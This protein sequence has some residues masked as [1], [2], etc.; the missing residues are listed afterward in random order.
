M[1]IQMRRGSYKD[2]DPTKLLPGEMAVVLD[3]D[4]LDE[5]GVYVNFSS[6]NTQ[7]LATTDSIKAS[8]LAEND[9][10]VND[11]IE[12]NEKEIKDIQSDAQLAM[13]SANEAYDSA[14]R[15]A[16]EAEQAKLAANTATTTANEAKTIATEAKASAEQAVTTA[17]NA[18]NTASQTWD[19]LAEM[20][21]AGQIAG[22]NL[23]RNSLVNGG[24]VSYNSSQGTYVENKFN[25]RP[26]YK[27]TAS[28]QGIVFSNSDFYSRNGISVGNAVT[29][30][31]YV[32]SEV[33][34]EACT[35]Y[36]YRVTSTSATS[37]IQTNA[38]LTSRTDTSVKV[39]MSAGV[40]Y[41]LWCTF[42]TT[43]YTLSATSTRFEC[44]LDKELWWSSPKAEKG[45]QVTDWTPA[46]EDYLT[47]VDEK[48]EKAQAT[49][50]QLFSRGE[51]LVVNG[52]AILKDNTNFSS[53]TFDGE[54]ANNSC[55]AFTTTETS[56]QVISSDYSFPVNPSL[57]YSFEMDAKSKNNKAQMY[58]FLSLFDIDNKEI[59]S[60]HCLYVTGTLTSLTQ[61]LK[62]GDTVVYLDDLSGWQTSGSADTQS[63]I[64]WN[65]KNSFGYEYPAETYSR[66]TTS[67]GLFEFSS[68][69][70]TN[71]TITLKKPWSG[72]SYSAGTQL[73]QGN[74]GSSFLYQGMTGATPSTTWTH[75]AGHY[76]GVN[77]TGQLDKGKFLPG[78]AYAKVGFLWDYNNADDQVWVTNISVKTD[79]QTGINE[80]KEVASN[81]AK[82]ATNYLSTNETGDVCLGNLTNT[83][84]KGNV[85]LKTNGVS[86][87]ND[88]RVLVDVTDAK[89]TLGDE[90]QCCVQVEDDQLYIVGANT[91]SINDNSFN[92]FIVAQGNSG[93]WYYRKYKSGKAECFAG[94]TV[95]P[96]MTT[97]YGGIYYDWVTL[98]NF[99]FTFVGYPS[100]VADCSCG[101]GLIWVAAINVSTTG[102]T[103]LYCS[104]LS[105]SDS[106]TLYIR[107]TG[108]WK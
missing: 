76:A 69:D 46:P 44:S 61:E 17:D 48:A 45:D 92:D 82:T 108:E 4:P 102:G 99:P 75:Y 32:M 43:E 59:S 49:A 66:N 23:L 37:G 81:S 105:N 65:Y 2:F 5:T 21:S 11:L 50:D 80:A 62:A 95:A 15:S 13:L 47:T 91:I 101:T 3:G 18:N 55:G 26:A 34:V 89:A 96:S 87:R 12:K 7:R 39:N 74:R 78:A 83:N 63:F 25:G 98:P 14:R 94:L 41:R 38:P 33:D 19:F 68:V 42:D 40:W 57:S 51:Q 90:E 36:L 20:Q 107:A 71:N 1:A 64:F 103:V 52:S 86:L 8:I 56:Y 67:T 24:D 16:D 53:L 100:V 60:L 70:K 58:S 35:F 84:Y 77:Y 73:S 22:R 27:T 9:S 85:L 54:Q 97:S 93:K 28:W 30:S 88:E 29:L 106:R 6:T 10:I 31:V 79:Y 72:G 104:A